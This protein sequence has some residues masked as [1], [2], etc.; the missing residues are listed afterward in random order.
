[1]AAVE[2]YNL[3]ARSAGE[4]QSMDG[5]NIVVK[6]R[7]VAVEKNPLAVLFLRSLLAREEH[8]DEYTVKIIECDMRHLT[9]HPDIIAMNPAGRGGIADIVVSE[10]LGSFGDNELSPE[11]LDGVER[12]GL[13]KDG[14]VSIPKHYT[15]FLAPVS[16]LRLHSEAQAQAYSPSSPTDGP[17]G[18]PFGIQRALETA[19]VVR[20]HASSQTH[21]EKPLFSFTHP[22]KCPTPNDRYSSLFFAPGP[23]AV[24]CGYGSPLPPSNNPY[25]FTLH[26]F[27]GTFSAVLYGEI[28][29]SIAPHNFS[30]GMF[31]W[32]P[33]YFPVRVPLA[34]SPG[35]GV[36]AFFWR[37]VEKERVWYEWCAEVEGEGGVLASSGLHNPNGRSSHVKL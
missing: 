17:G 14:C 7:I 31:S 35:S 30:E 4:M 6:A 3:T 32:F 21:T 9:S 26:G 20:C 18:Q 8:W 28:T 36:R 2:A 23:N 15:S 5:A 12:L 24:G 10:L 27:L 29:I 33:L 25:G 37:R 34:V 13:M 16:S 1:L 11:C 19:Y 22:K